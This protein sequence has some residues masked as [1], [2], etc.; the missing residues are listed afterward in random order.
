MSK[1]CKH[2]AEEGKGCEG[3]RGSRL[4]VQA[5]LC[6]RYFLS[7]PLGGKMILKMP[8][9]EGGEM[10]RGSLLWEKPSVTLNHP[11]TSLRFSPRLS[12]LTTDTDPTAAAAAGSVM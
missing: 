11:L 12:S 1:K 10:R 5:A 6:E 3:L 4:S 2:S 9:G 8:L 7:H